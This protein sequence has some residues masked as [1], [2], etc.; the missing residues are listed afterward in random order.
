MP[1][2]CCLSRGPCRQR[3]RI[4]FEHSSKKQLA[5]RCPPTIQHGENSKIYPSRVFPPA[6]ISVFLKYLLCASSIIV[7]ADMFLTLS[8]YVVPT[9]L[10]NCPGILSRSVRPASVEIRLATNTLVRE[11]DKNMNNWMP[12]RG[13][14]WQLNFTSIY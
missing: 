12:F 11:I 4:P 9:G 5:W 2:L 6:K 3:A 7:R 1:H 10:S 13:V 8:V 14:V